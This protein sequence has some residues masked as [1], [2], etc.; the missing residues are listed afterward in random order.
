MAVGVVDALEV[1]Q[2]DHQQ[3]DRALAVA[4]L[5]DKPLEGLVEMGAVVQFGEAVMATELA[6]P[7][8]RVLELVQGVAQLGCAL[9]HL[10][11]EL[12]ARVADN[13]LVQ[14]AQ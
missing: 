4:G 6:Q 13:A 5:G 14:V 10:V 12:V 11:L 9:L 7:L 8:V 1:V 2:V 3:G